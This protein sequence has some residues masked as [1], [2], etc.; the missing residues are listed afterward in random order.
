MN[1]RNYSAADFALDNHFQK[2]ILNPDEETSRFWMDWLH[3]NPHMKAEVEEAT[4]LMKL[5]GLASDAAANTA[6]LDVWEK[7]KDNAEQQE[8]VL[9]SAIKR[10]YMPWVAALVA[11]LAVVAVYLVVISE[12][13]VAVYTTAYGEVKEYILPDGSSATLNANSKLICEGDWVSERKVTLEGEAFFQVKKTADRKTFTVKTQDDVTVK[14]LGT[15]FNVNARHNHPV[16]YLQEGK[17]AFSAKQK[18]VVLEPG[19]LATMDGTGQN[20][21]ITHHAEDSAAG[22]L[23]WRSNFFVYNDAP[24]SLIARHLEDNFGLDVVLTDSSLCNKRVTF[25]T[26]QKRIS[27]LLEIIAQTLDVTVEQNKNQ[28][29]ISPRTRD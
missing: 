24:L 12:K 2:W 13:P 6:F 28:I 23:A 29:I 5:S 22:E 8:T 26:T 27:I 9:H 10:K 4:A 7:L 17:I 25:K 20:I 21:Y 3:D 11:C 1:Y 18:E 15:K 14:V 19:D 16:V